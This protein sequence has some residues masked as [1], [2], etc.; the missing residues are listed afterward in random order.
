MKCKNMQK[1]I[2]FQTNKLILLYSLIQEMSNY[3]FKS[4]FAKYLKDSWDDA[5]YIWAGWVGREKTTFF[6]IFFSV[7]ISTTRL[8]TTATASSSSQSTKTTSISRKHRLSNFEKLQQKG[9]MG[10][11]NFILK[12]QFT[13]QTYGLNR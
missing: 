7:V 13:H 2:F 4:I 6:N 8:T 5:M 11:W 10:G 1:Y 12:G 3:D 9:K